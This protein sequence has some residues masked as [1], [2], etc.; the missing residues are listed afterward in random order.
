M[1]LLAVV[2]PLHLQRRSPRDSGGA[3]ALILCAVKLAQL[4]SLF[5]SSVG[6][7]MIS[8]LHLLH[9]LCV[10]EGAFLFLCTIYALNM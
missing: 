7:N 2:N 4:V 8:H 9:R 1:S 6:A 10:C 5:L 3:A